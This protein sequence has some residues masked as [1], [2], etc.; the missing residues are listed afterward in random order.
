MLQ[1]EALDNK[2]KCSGINIVSRIHK[3]HV[4]DFESISLNQIKTSH[5]ISQHGSGANYIFNQE[6]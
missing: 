1:K 3:Q 6:P 4:V 2:R 5:K